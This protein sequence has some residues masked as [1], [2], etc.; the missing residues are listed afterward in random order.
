METLRESPPNALSGESARQKAV[1]RGTA[2]G[3]MGEDEGGGGGPSGLS[4]GESVKGHQP[5]KP[6]AK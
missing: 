3:Q 2:G 1:R 6:K 4:G 5:V